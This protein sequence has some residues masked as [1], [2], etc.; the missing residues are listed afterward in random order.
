MN[1]YYNLHNTCKDLI[2]SHIGLIRPPWLP[3]NDQKLWMVSGHYLNSLHA[4]LLGRNIN[5]YMYLNF[6][7]TYFSTL[8]WCWQLK[9]ILHGWQGPTGLTDNTCISISSRS[10]NLMCAEYPLGSTEHLVFHGYQTFCA[11]FYDS[12]LNDVGP[13]WAT[14]AGFW[15]SVNFTCHAELQGN[16][17]IMELI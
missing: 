15:S 3:P 4:V 2:F 7:I 14:V 1:G 12:I 13:I 9:K 16:M 11:I 8:K 17:F 10:V 5:I 6:F